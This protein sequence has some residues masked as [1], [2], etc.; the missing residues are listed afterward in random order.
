[1]HPTIMEDMR[2]FGVGD[3]GASR[4]NNFFCDVPVISQPV[5]MPRMYQSNPKA[6]LPG[7][8][9]MYESLIT[10]HGNTGFKLQRATPLSEGT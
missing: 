3:V 10:G 6:Y 8:Y 2:S 1:M 5:P 9:Q 4:F 7:N